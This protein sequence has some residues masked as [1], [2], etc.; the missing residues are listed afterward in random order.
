MP[1]EEGNVKPDEETIPKT[2]LHA[3][4]EGREED[5]EGDVEKFKSDD[6]KDLGQEQIGGPDLGPPAHEKA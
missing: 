4:K 3:Y 2:S 5:I 1:D 6:P